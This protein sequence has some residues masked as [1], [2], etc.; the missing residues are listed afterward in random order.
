MKDLRERTIRG[1]VAKVISQATNFVLRV[2][3]VMIL[4][5]LLEPRD[6]GLVGMVTA[7]IGVLNLFRDFGL[8][9]ATVQRNTVTDGQISTLFWINMLVGAILGIASA[10]IAPLVATFYHEPRLVWV[11]LVLASGF[12]FNAAGVQHGAILQRQMRFTSLAVIEII[13]LVASTAVGIGMA[14]R[15]FGYWALVGMTIVGPIVS[16]AGVWLVTA[17]IPAR[18]TKETEI[19]SLMRFGGTITLNGLVVY[20]AY[21]LEKVLLGRYWGAAT[22]GIYGRAYQLISIPTEN[23]NSA[24]GGVA[25]AALSR[26][27]DDPIR[28]KN[29]FLKAYSLLLALTVPISVIC[30]FFAKDLIFVLL[31]QKWA[32]AVPIFRLLAPTMLIFGMINPLWWLHYSIGL[33]K[34]S[35]TVASVISA[36]V[37]IGYLIGLSHGPQGVAFAYSAVLTL[38]AIPHLAW[39]VR[40]TMLSLRELLMAVARPLFSSLLGAALALTAQLFYGPLLPALPR[41]VLDVLIVCSVYVGML[42]YVMG[43]KD[44]Y[45]DLLSGL[46]KRPEVK[47]A[48]L[49]SA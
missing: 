34:R 1:G 12:I 42:L 15:G 8:S 37:V 10:A 44:L 9:T 31:G 46:L 33:V 29:Y 22:V 13:S 43:Q 26:L 27:Q 24:A 23:L 30:G 36:L 6:F 47:E 35:L 49:A 40:G 5:R 17:W 20:V 18:P 45:L 16:S 14:L 21:N 41:L 3:S 48:A 25:F 2:G 39:C 32:E 7:I 28:L 19:W 11:T 4:G 38:W